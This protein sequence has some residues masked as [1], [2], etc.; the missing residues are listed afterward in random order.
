[1][2]AI[3]GATDQLGRLVVEQLLDKVPANDIVAAV[4][5]PDKAADLAARGVEV[6]VADYDDPATLD[7]AFSGIGKLLFISSSEVGQRARQHGNVIAAAKRAGVELV[8]YTSVLRADES[9]LGLAEEHRQTEAALAASGIDHVL[10][11]NG[12]YTENYLAAIPA[13]LEHG[14]VLGS[15]G[16]GRISAAPRRDFAEA[17]AAVLTRDGQ[18]GTVYELGGDES[19]TLAEL[20][21]EISA[22]SGQTVAYRNLTQAEHEAALVEAGLPGPVAALLADAD[23]GVAEGALQED[24]GSLSRLIGRPTTPLA[25]LIGSALA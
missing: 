5:N 25:T 19:F 2:I 14:V 13:A 8:I 24:G 20:A 21:R 4:R 3:T 7:A 15:A 6:R 18:A 17:A 10:L 12:W 23:A 22:Q 9:P 11:R 1:M 16:E